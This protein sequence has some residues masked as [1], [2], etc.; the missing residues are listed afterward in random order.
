[1]NTSKRYKNYLK[2]RNKAWEV[3]IKCKISSL[4]LDLNLIKNYYGIKVIPY[5]KA[6]N[7]NNFTEDMKN[8]DGFSVEIK[9]EKIIYFN[10]KKV[11]FERRRFTIAH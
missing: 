10:D 1:M 2:A 4:P 9:G 11:T 3:L 8:G 6:K 5:S 7:Y